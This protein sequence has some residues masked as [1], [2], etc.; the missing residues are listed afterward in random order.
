M[1]GAKPTSSLVD[2]LTRADKFRNLADCEIADYIDKRDFLEDAC[3]P[4]AAA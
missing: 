1:R 2:T 4:H 3:P